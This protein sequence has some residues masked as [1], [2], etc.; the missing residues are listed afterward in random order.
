MAEV[1]KEDKPIGRSR[2]ALV[3]VLTEGDVLVLDGEYYHVTSG[4]IS[5]YADKKIDKR[6]GDLAEI[7]PDALPT[8]IAQRKHIV[9]VDEL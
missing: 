4:E 3:E 7:S 6:L 1:E 2:N 9:N 5:V 8:L